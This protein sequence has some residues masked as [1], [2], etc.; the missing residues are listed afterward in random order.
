MPNKHNLSK[1]HHIKKTP[2]D[3]PIMPI[4]IK[5]CGRVEA[6]IFG[7]L[8]TFWK[9]GKVSNALMMGQAHPLNTLIAQLERAII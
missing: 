3:H 5:V 8:M 2:I 4:T 1:R 9:I 7:Y 6:L